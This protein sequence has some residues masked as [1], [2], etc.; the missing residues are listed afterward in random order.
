MKRREFIAL[1]A[2]DR[3]RFLL[4]AGATLSGGL[5]TPAIARVPAPYD[6]NAAPPT[7]DKSSFVDWM[8]RSRGEDAGFLGRR[9]DCSRSWSSTVTSGIIVTCAHSC[10]RRG[11]NSLQRLI[12]AARM[13]WFRSASATA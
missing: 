6:W 5:Y 2:L 3:R 4:G 13:N 10:S 7:K 9:W 8:A 12:G 1:P 11:R